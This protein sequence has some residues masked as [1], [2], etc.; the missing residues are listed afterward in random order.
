MIPI[1]PTKYISEGSIIK[2]QFC[3]GPDIAKYAKYV[4]NEA[5]MKTYILEVVD[6]RIY[7]KHMGKYDESI[8]IAKHIHGSNELVEVIYPRDSVLIVEPHDNLII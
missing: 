6:N 7:P 8:I 2:V 1:D 4:Q 3:G 5:F